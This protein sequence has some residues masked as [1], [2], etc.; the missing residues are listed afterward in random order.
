M[1]FRFS[2]AAVLRLRES[3]EKREELLLQTLQMGIA[4]LR[5]RIE[6]LTEEIEESG[7]RLHRAMQLPLEAWQIQQGISELN[8][9]IEARQNLLLE[10]EVALQ[11]QKEQLNIYRAAIKD[12]QTLTEMR[13]EKQ[14]EYDQRQERIQQRF[15][16]DV[17][18][19]RFQDR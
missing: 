11:K 6:Q 12:R 10:L 19:A 16:D 9:A 1:G 14:S 3:I 15:L 18:A 7:R 17:F 8:R 13:A 5:R 4:Q 2:L